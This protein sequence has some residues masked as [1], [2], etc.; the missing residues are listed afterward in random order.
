MSRVLLDADILSEIIK[1]KNATVTAQARGYVAVHKLYTL[2]SI[3]VMEIAF[4]F[5]WVGRYDRLATFES[6][7]SA[8]EVLPFDTTAAALAGR[9]DADLE[10]RGTPINQADIM[11]AAIAIGAGLPIVTGNVAHFEAVRAAGYG[12][13]IENWRAPCPGAANHR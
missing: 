1:G 7:I 4:G 8:C 2:S 5:Q 13:P 3:T 6:F 11:I 12:V 10:K 9:I